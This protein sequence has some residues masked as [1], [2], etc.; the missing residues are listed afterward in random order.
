MAIAGRVMLVPKG[1]YDPSKVYNTLDL[2]SH[3][4]RPWIC[5]KQGI[6]GVEPTR[7]NPDIWML[8]IDVD[9]TNADT[10]DGYDSAYFTSKKDLSAAF[11]THELIFRAANWVGET[12][13][14]TQIVQLQSIKNT[15]TPVAFFVDDGA[16]ETESKAK[17][18][19]FG[20]VTFFDSENGTITATCKYDK[21]ASDFTVGFKGVGL[22]G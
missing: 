1:E 13:P 2:V 8:L 16:S 14:Y 18:K 3:N 19:A 7:S 11:M 15:D 20:C 12:A 9:I 4:E 22:N 17:K 10:L 6:V 21:P 5:R